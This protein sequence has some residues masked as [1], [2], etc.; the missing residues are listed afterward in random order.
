MS[1]PAEPQ[2]RIELRHYAFLALLTLLNVV[3]FVD[4][5]ALPSFAN[6]IKPELALSDTQWGLLTGIAFIVFY[7]TMGLF[8]GA[9]AD[10]FHR[11]R[12]I[13]IGLTL[14]S[15]LTAAT[16]FAT[17]F[18]S[19]A[20]ARALIGVGESVLTPTAM[21]I[22]SDRF[23]ASRLGLAS[24]LYY[25]GVPIGS[26]V[27]LLV[28]GY[29]APEMGWRGCFKLLGVI[30]LVFAAVMLFV[31]ETP[32]KKPAG[33]AAAA[34]QHS[35]AEISAIVGSALRSSPA[36][37][38]TM[39]G[40]IAFHFILGAAVVDQLWLANER[41]FDRAYIAQISGW[42]AV[43]GGI[44]G[45]ILGG[46]GS[47]WFLRRT[48]LGRPTFLA[49][50]IVLFAPLAFAYRLADPAG[51]WFW[52]GMILGSVQLGMFYGPTFASVQELVPPNVRATVV[53]L[54]IMLLNVVG[55]GIGI[56]GSGVMIDALRAEGA[57]DPYTQTLVAF[58]ALS[59]LALPLFW[60]AGRRFV[61]DREA[62]YAKLGAGA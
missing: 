34:P 5:Q 41:G 15:L 10:M 48:G 1:A 17:G 39:G 24:G 37:L 43:A 12:L 32:R 44:T 3:N 46:M 59:L 22:L 50:L 38:C 28:A 36:L 31:R 55:L 21:S 26:G 52:L 11:P 42:I 47:D 57:A 45:N 9:L 29:L 20:A 56:T 30:G 13:T 61:R 25:M 35:L 2:D 6:F 18:W 40:G 27:S 16:G 7:A 62:L 4:R 60:Y 8:T 58:T 33:A 23:P 14:W 53:G 51:P 19:L 54:Y 49:L